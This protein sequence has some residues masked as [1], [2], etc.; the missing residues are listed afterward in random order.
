M[1]SVELKMVMQSPVVKRLVRLDGEVKCSCHHILIGVERICREENLQLPDNV[2]GA[3][4]LICTISEIGFIVGFK[5][6]TF[7]HIQTH[8]QAHIPT[9]TI[10]DLKAF[11]GFPEIADIILPQRGSL[12]SAYLPD[13][14]HHALY[15]IMNN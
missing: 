10:T 11:I 12:S 1:K 4:Y 7:I 6:D 9:D 15:I 13:V 3:F 5:V 2:R 8:T 14:S